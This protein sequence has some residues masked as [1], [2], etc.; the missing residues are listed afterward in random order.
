MA[1]ISHWLKVAPVGGEGVVNSNSTL[2]RVFWLWRKPSGRKAK[3]VN[4]R[5]LK[6]GTVTVQWLTQFIVVVEIGDGLQA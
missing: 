4:N 6:R 5:H 2:V 3:G 1:G